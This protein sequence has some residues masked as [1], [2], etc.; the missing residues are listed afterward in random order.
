MDPNHC[1]MFA[2]RAMQNRNFEEALRFLSMLLVQLPPT[3]PQ[4]AAPLLLQRA[5][6]FW[7]L[8]EFGASLQDMT[9]AIRAGLPDN[10][11][12]AG[13]ESQHWTNRGYILCQRGD[14]TLAEMCANVAL[15]FRPSPPKL[16]AQPFLCRAIARYEM[17][18][19]SGTQQDIN[20]TKELDL[21]LARD[22]AL[23]QKDFAIKEFQQKHYEKSMKLLCLALMLHPQKGS[24][25]VKFKRSVE[26]HQAAAYFNMK[27]Y[28]EALHVGEGSHQENPSEKLTV[29]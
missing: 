18:N 23:L 3:A 28:R 7:E 5:H 2:Q 16:R 10:G 15:H 13:T 14:Y 24:D 21:E 26:S 29:C 19:T 8:G 20:K 25:W 11:Q 22:S 27:R 1:A 4:H 17:G 6:C 9:D 12:N